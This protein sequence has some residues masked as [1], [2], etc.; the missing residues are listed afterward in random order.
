MLIISFIIFSLSFI[1]VALLPINKKIIIS[2][3]VLSI[4]IIYGMDAWCYYLYFNEDINHK[5][6]FVLLI[7]SDCAIL[8]LLMVA[9][10]FQ[11]DSFKEPVF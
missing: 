6:I 8:P 10:Y 2:T 9:I 4:I 5:D 3:I 11:I 7:Y 1:L